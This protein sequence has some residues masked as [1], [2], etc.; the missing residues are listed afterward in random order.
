M[1]ASEGWQV[2]I[3]SVQAELAYILLELFFKV[4]LNM[5]RFQ[6]FS[7]GPLIVHAWTT[8]HYK[9]MNL[10]FAQCVLLPCESFRIL[11]KPVYD[12]IPKTVANV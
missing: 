4:L 6:N 7:Y 1:D 5:L 9:R 2:V 12:V 3:I 11:M 10:D 8:R